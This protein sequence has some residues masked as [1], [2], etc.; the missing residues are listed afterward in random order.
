MQSVTGSGDVT[1]GAAAGAVTA[2]SGSG[3]VRVEDSARGVG[4][5]TA[6][7]DV[8]IGRLTGGRVD[9]RTASGDLSVAVAAGVPTWTDINTMTG[10]VRSSLQSLGE[11]AEGQP[12]VE[13]R[14]RTVSGDI[15]VGHLADTTHD[16]HQP[17]SF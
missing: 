14:L 2:K 16:T 11:P 1:L 15:V 10:D 6:S 8:T 17:Q 13:L 12:Y 9:A 5:T 3:D 7:G 4:A